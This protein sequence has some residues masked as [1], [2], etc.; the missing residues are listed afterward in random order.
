MTRI[1]LIGGTGVESTI[2]YYRYLCYGVKNRLKKDFL[3]NLA[4]ESLS[5]FEV[6][7][8]CENKDYKGLTQYLLKGIERLDASGCEYVSFTGI[9]PHIVFEEVSR[10]SPLPLVSIIQAC[11]EYTL[12]QGFKKV[13]LLATLPTMNGDFFQKPFKETGIEVLLPNRNE[14]EFIGEKIKAEIEHG[15]I[16]SSTKQSFIDITTRLIK[17]ERLEA[18]ILGCTELPLLFKGC[19]LDVPFIDVMQVHID[20]LITLIIDEKNG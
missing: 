12:K 17:D 3:P 16:T 2:L 11:K 9:T 14:R 1:G 13:A 15:I 5:V 19:K 18:I 8:Y 7:K 20:K 4:I 10:L 6:L